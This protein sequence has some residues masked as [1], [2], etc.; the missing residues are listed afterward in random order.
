MDSLSKRLPILGKWFWIVIF[1]LIF[2]GAMQLQD[3][4]TAAAIAIAWENTEMSDIPDLP[5]VARL[6]IQCVSFLI[7]L[8]SFFWLQR[9]Y[10]DTE[11]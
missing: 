10:K 8:Y 9:K 5:L 4:I 6:L 11:I 7:F 3:A 1:I 2:L